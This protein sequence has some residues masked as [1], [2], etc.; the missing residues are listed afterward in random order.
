MDFI[1]LR[2]FRHP[3][4]KSRKTKKALKKQEVV[5]V[6]HTNFRRDSAAT[7][8]QGGL[9]RYSTWASV[10]AKF[11]ISKKGIWIPAPSSTEE[12]TRIR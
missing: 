10:P 7:A 1:L 9:R 2:E 5:S 3:E 11:S 6:T 4:V 8:T 12:A